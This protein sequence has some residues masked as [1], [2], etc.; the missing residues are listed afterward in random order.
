MDWDD[1]ILT[2]TQARY[3]L[4]RARRRRL[5]AYADSRIFIE[6]EDGVAARMLIDPHVKAGKARRIAEVIYREMRVLEKILKK[7]A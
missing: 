4:L 3:K 7:F 1:N 2:R 6:Y 5:I